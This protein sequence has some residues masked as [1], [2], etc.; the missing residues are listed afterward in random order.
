MKILNITYNKQSGGLEQSFID[1]A[2]SMQQRGHEVHCLTCMNSGFETALKKK[3]NHI[4]YS[5]FLR[6]KFFRFL[7]LLE[8]KLILKKIQPDMVIL[9]NERNIDIIY[10]AI[11]GKCPL[12]AV[13]HGGKIKKITKFSNHIFTVN[14]A[15]AE[16]IKAHH[17]KSANITIIGN[18]LEI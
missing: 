5:K 4:H 18:M 10:K 8:L 9:H 1:Y 2:F 3:I 13:N 6:K 14:R 16:Q 11:N 7:L 12:V 17:Y 15:I